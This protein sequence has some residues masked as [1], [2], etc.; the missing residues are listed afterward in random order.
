M[1]LG[2]RRPSRAAAREVIVVDRPRW[3]VSIDAGGT[4]TDAVARADDG[5][6]LVAKAASTPMTRRVAWQTPSPHSQPGH[7]RAE[8]GLLCH[9]T[10][11]AT[12]AMLTGTWRG[13]AGDDR[14]FRD[15]IGY[16]NG[17]PRSTA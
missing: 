12:N 13:R 1:Y 5:G 4:F 14:G 9:G 15:V 16:R 7:A 3:I 17:T 6:A 2:A 10:T 8:V 11:V